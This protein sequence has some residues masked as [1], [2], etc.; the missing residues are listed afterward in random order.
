MAEDWQPGDLALCVRTAVDAS[1][2]SGRFYT[3][4]RVIVDCAGTLALFLVGLQNGSE[5][6]PEGFYGHKAS[7][8]RKIRPHVPDEE[9]AETIRLLTGAPIREPVA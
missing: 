3:V 5:W 1:T 8:F 6:G 4:E 2:V 7:R 9:D